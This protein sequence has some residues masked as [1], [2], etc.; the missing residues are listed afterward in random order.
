MS[1]HTWKHVCWY[2]LDDLTVD[3]YGH[4]RHVFDVEK[5]N[6]LIMES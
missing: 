2:P 1:G 4:E 3:S 5:T 6:T